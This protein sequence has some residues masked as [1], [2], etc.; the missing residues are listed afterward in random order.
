MAGTGLGK[1]ET[2]PKTLSEKNENLIFTV[3]LA[4]LVHTL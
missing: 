2:E 3:G 1:R 4:L